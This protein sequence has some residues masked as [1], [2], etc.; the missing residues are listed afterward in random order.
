MTSRNLYFKLTKEHLKNRLWAVALI[1]L[2]FFF[3]FPV[4]ATF[5]AGDLRETENYLAAVEEYGRHMEALVSFSFPFTVFL[6][7]VSAVICGMSSFSYLNSRSKVDFYH[8]IPVR[9]ELLYLV[10]YINGILILAVPYGVMLFAGTAI[11]VF[12]GA[13]SSIW[14]TALT[15]YGLTMVYGILLYSTVIVAVMLTGHLVVSFLG[16]AVFSF[17]IPI[18]VMIGQAYFATFFQTYVSWV[19]D[20]LA[21][22][23]MRVSPVVEYIWQIG[24]YEE[25]QPVQ[26]VFA[27]AAALILTV[28][29]G[30]L[31]K[32]R[33]SEAAGHAMAFSISRPIISAGITV[34][35]ALMLGMF[36]WS[37]RSSTS[38]AVFG[39]LCGGVISHCVIQVIYYF[40]FKKLFS[41]RIHLAGCLL[42]SLAIL[43]IFRY[44]WIGYDRYLPETQEIQSVAVNIRS[45]N[46]WV[47]Y[48]SAAMDETGNYRWQDLDGD[49]Y[50]FDQMKLTD[51]ETALSLVQAGQACM[52]QNENSS[53]GHSYY[54]YYSEQDGVREYYISLEIAYT[55][56]N[57]KQVYRGYDIPVMSNMENLEKLYAQPA[58]Q[59]TI[60]P[61]LTLDPKEVAQIRIRD[62]GPEKILDELTKE[63][64]ADFLSV[65]Q[66]EL[67]QMTISQ[68]QK[69]QPVALI[70][71]MDGTE[72]QAVGWLDQQIAQA[73][74]ENRGYYD[75]TGLADQNFYPI[76][77]S[78]TETLTLMES[79]GVPAEMG[80]LADFATS[81]DVVYYDDEKSYPYRE[82]AFQI[83]DPE[84]VRELT[85]AVS[86]TDYGYYNRMY[87]EEDGWSL[88]IHYKTAEGKSAELTGD[89]S[90][91]NVPALLLEKLEE[92]E[93][94]AAAAA[95]D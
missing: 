95:A 74:R 94:A 58:F 29:G 88:T 7:M 46:G 27:A 80:N 92:A 59:N 56:K 79:Y 63:Q 32:K 20:P 5:L 49:E 86:V 81:I 48:G 38:W 25:L 65:Y 6:V 66:K 28:L 40:D 26:A 54:G 12:H 22:S 45:L 67:S 93:A 24:R 8:S 84:E 78:F 60:Y 3:L 52:E 23:L 30:F 75:R 77:P 4:V 90:R 61:L 53:Y 39:V 70:R 76:Y 83:Q 9:R 44:D 85:E 51:L 34:L 31:Y 71:F 72:A 2:A 10:N 14:S 64:R 68:M 1:A 33:P 35:S 91:Q 36:F 37:M 73:E 57:G 18:A 87:Q 43:G 21:E 42:V 82:T 17:L 13:P 50:V 15:G 41:A 47:S 69:E 55:L 89:V 11:G 62:M 16:I 19:H